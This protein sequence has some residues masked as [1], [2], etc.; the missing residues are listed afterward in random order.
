MSDDETASTKVTLSVSPA[1][2]DEGADSTTI[3]VTG[4]LDH[5]PRT[6]ATSVTVAVGAT[7]DTAIEGTDYT[8]VADF[9]LTISAGQATGTATFSLAPTDDEVDEVDDETISIS[10]TTTAAGLNVVSTALTIDDNETATQGTGRGVTV[11]PTGMTVSEGSSS[12][13]TVVLDTEPTANVTV[14][15]SGTADTDLSLNKTSLTFTAS[16][17]ETAQTVTV[18]AAED[19]DAEDDKATLAHAVSGGD[20]GT[21]SVTADDVAVTVDD[22]ETASTKVTLSVSPASVDEDADETTVTVT[23]T[24][25][26]A[27]GHPT[28]A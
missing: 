3:T 18:S 10:G 23:G 20:Y 21:N 12:S 17:W 19:A 2:V 16:N 7:A 26:A 22:D 11:S 24:L 6:S 13:Y 5:A 9:T 25:D 14:T 8:A 15:I 1:S 4:T 28:R 27:P